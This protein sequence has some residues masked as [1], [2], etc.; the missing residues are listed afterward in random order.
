MTQDGSQMIKIEIIV[1]GKNW[2]S[3]AWI[4]IGLTKR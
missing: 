1:Q 4:K 3:W 2:Q